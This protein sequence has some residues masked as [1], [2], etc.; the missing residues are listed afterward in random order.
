MM[1]TSIRASLQTRFCSATPLRSIGS[2]GMAP[3]RFG[4]A[5]VHEVAEALRPVDGSADVPHPLAQ[6]LVRC[7]DTNFGWPGVG[8]HQPDDL[9]VGGVGAPRGRM[10]YLDHRRADDG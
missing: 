5:W 9:V 1:G 10:G 2:I 7:H 4:A 6:R 8:L 3:S